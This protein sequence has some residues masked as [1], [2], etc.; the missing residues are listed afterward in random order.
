MTHLRAMPATG[1]TAVGRTSAPADLS[2]ASTDSEGSMDLCANVV[3]TPTSPEGDILRTE[4]VQS[5]MDE[6]SP[7]HRID[8]VVAPSH[9]NYDTGPVPNRSTSPTVTNQFLTLELHEAREEIERLKKVIDQQR[10]IIAN[11]KKQNVREAKQ[12]ENVTDA[13]HGSGGDLVNDIPPESSTI[14]PALTGTAE[15]SGAAAGVADVGTS[16]QKSLDAVGIASV[17]ELVMA[18]VKKAGKRVT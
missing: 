14:P 15:A 17:G 8:V 5:E 18:A 7:D 11:M 9:S 2:A 12:K 1:T 10:K 16:G 3:A 13:H 6:D 4:N